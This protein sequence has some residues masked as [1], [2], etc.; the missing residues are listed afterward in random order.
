MEYAARLDHVVT[1]FHIDD[2]SIDCICGNKVVKI[3]KSTG[4]VI[5]E[6][7][8]F[9]KEGFSRNLMATESQIIIR[10][11]CML[12]ILD[13][14][15]YSVLSSLSLGTD[16][17]SD[18]CGMTVDE[19]HIYALIRNGKIAVIDRVTFQIK[20]YDLANHSMWD[21][22]TY[23]NALIGGS[24]DGKLLWINKDDMTISKSMDL[25]KQNVRSLVIETDII[26]SASQDKKLSKI[27]LQEFHCI[28]QKRNVH[29]KMFDCIGLFENNLL[30]VSY[31]CS[32]IS[33][34]D[35]DTLTLTKTINQ[36]LSLSGNT[37]IEDDILY[38]TSRNILGIGM[39]HLH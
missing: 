29:K 5:L 2:T 23:K 16:L 22:R 28:T 31:P 25:A 7:I 27:D 19:N 18:I 35:K 21:I 33:F 11:F 26:Y 36:P 13:K 4:K 30:T 8:L 38:I 32:E 10:D 12:H 6:S 3:E 15:N 17:S 20:T 34:W 1:G 37:W 14:A 9:E 39:I 24:V